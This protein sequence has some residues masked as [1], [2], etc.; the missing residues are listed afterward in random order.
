MI[1]S[2]SSLSSSCLVA[3]V[4]V[5]GL[6]LAACGN[7]D[8]VTPDAMPAPD[9][10]EPAALRIEPPTFTFPDTELG[11]TAA[12]TFTVTN[13]GGLAAP[14]VAVQVDDDVHYRIR[15]SS[16]GGELAAGASCSVDVELTPRRAGGLPA[17]LSATDGTGRAVAVLGATGLARVTVTRTGPGIITSDPPGIDCGDVCT[18]LFSS[19]TVTLSATAPSAT[20]D[21]WGGACTGSGTCTLDLAAA[22]EV[23]ATFTA[24]ACQPDTATC[25]GNLLTRCGPTGQPL[26]DPEACALGCS[27]TLGRCEDLTPSNGLAAALDQARTGPDV[28]IPDGSIIHV[29]TGEIVA[30]NG[31]RIEVPSRVVMQPGAPAGQLYP[32]IRVF[33]VKSIV[34]N[35]VTVRTADISA[36]LFATTALAIAADGDIKVQGL[37]AAAGRGDERAPGTSLLA[38]TGCQG[39][40]VTS[41][42]SVPGFGG[43]GG[44]GHVSAGGAGG[45][46][47]TE[48]A[49][50]G[51]AAYNPD[52][53]PLIGG[54]FGGARTQ[55]GSWG[56]RGG[57][58]GGAVQ[59]VSRT[60][61]TVV[62]NSHGRGRIDVGGGGGTGLGMGGGAGGSVLLEA[63]T[64]VITGN[65][66]G[67]GANGGAGAGG[68]AGGRGED[69][70]FASQAAAGGTC[71]ANAW[72]GGDGGVGNTMPEP[73]T[74][75]VGASA[76]FA[77]GG[78]GGARGQLR[79]NTATGEYTLGTGAVIHATIATG[80]AGRR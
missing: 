74:S 4:L 29:E 66:A 5:Q 33:M 78:G 10:G 44:G 28:V 55:S 21:G 31:E 40:S 14:A 70:R 73:G 36:T 39:G 23:A 34:V 57:A 54:C 7:L 43:A 25:S 49:A 24:W 15:A 52:L 65:G 8:A 17:S 50:A 62:N 56:V 19:P 41:N 11:T 69:G 53:V 13:H 35:D 20:F 30:P 68:C 38:A 26:G 60:S 18:G 2:R 9:A 48:A 22:A 16:C 79:I 45:R 27:A 63:P 47:Q 64:V 51:A 71:T 46:H 3:T 12:A 58:G 72:P 61:I 59:L 75:T 67:I 42:D 37:I 1:S 76:Q 80:R 6:A 77:A 32:G